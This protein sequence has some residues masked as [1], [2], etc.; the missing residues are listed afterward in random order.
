MLISRGFADAGRLAQAMATVA[1]NGTLPAEWAPERPALVKQPL[2][3]FLFPDTYSLYRGISEVEILRAMAGRLK[4]SVTGEMKA[5]AAQL[6][7]SLNE[8]LTLASIIEKEARREDERAIISGVYHNRLRINMALQACPTVRY[9]MKDPDGP[10]TD[11]EMAIDSVYNTYVYPGLPP[12]PICSP[13]LASIIAALN[14][15]EVEYLYFVAKPDGSHAFARTLA[16]HNANVKK[17]L[18]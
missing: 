12:G 16:E 2:E 10:I 7:M 15:A 3:G 1:A 8:V 6:G 11:V 4:S 9:V 5:K 17:Y 14:P 13:G 18:H